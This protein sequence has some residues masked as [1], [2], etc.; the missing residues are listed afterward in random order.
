MLLRCELPE[1]GQGEGRPTGVRVWLVLK[2][3]EP[4]SY[5]CSNCL[6][7]CDTLQPGQHIERIWQHGLVM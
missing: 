3:G 7:L 6:V 1:L 2:A 5:C 4:S